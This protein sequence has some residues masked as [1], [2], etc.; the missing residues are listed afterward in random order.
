[1]MD[2]PQ[3]DIQIERIDD[4]TL[5]YGYLQKMDTQMIVDSVIT[6]HGNWQ[7]LTLGWVITNWLAYVIT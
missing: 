5:V 1:M 3:S 4:I 2:I 7:G 6:P